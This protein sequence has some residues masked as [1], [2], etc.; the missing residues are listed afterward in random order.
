MF[1]KDTYKLTWNY[2]IASDIL[3][4]D[5]NTNNIIKLE[6]VTWNHLIVYELF[7]LDKNT[8]YHRTL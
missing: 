2:I 3:L 4:L 8:W 6:L 1:T 7:V 5:R